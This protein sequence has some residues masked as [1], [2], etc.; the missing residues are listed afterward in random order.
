MAKLRHLRTLFERIARVDAGR[1]RVLVMRA[2][3]AGLFTT[4]GRGVNAPDMTAR[5]ATNT[6]LLALQMEPPGEAADAVAALRELPLV[7][8]RHDPGDRTGRTMTS[9]QYRKS[10]DEGL[11]LLPEAFGGK[12]PANLGDALDLL[13]SQ[14]SDTF[15]NRWDQI[16]HLRTDHSVVYLELADADYEPSN[17]WQTGPRAWKLIFWATSREHDELGAWTT[18]KVYAEALRAL[19]DLIHDPTPEEADEVL[20]DG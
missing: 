5:D 6:L 20:A 18:K 16:S 13:F 2:R 4:G 19:R 9:Q 8:L 3:A 11:E 10:G 17:Q 7:H 14:K 1:G 12:W 15:L